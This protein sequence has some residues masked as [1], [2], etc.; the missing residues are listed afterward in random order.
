MLVQLMKNLNNFGG[1][2][3]GCGH[4]G[5]KEADCLSKN[6]SRQGG[7]GSQGGSGKFKGQCNHCGNPGHKEA[8]CWSKHPEKNPFK[9]DEGCGED[10]GAAAV[11]VYMPTI[12]CDTF[13]EVC[14]M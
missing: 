7:G 2:C 9:K 6:T 3:F 10:T 12:E 14:D 13:C 1:T 5:P 4:K 11:E 8:D